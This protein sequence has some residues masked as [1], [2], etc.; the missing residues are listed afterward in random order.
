MPAWHP[1]G[2]TIDR[3][4]P[5]VFFTGILDSPS[6]GDSV[7]YAVVLVALCGLTLASAGEPE[8]VQVEILSGPGGGFGNLYL[9]GQQAVQRDLQLSPDQLAQVRT[10]VRDLVDRQKAFAQEKDQ[11]KRKALAEEAVR[12]RLRVD[13]EIL[14]LLK[15]GQAERL[16]QISLQTRSTASFFD[17]EVQAA[18]KLTDEQIA[19][20]RAIGMNDY[21]AWNRAAAAEF[22]KTRD[23]KVYQNRQAEIRKRRDQAQTQVLTAEQ[24]ARWRKMIGEPFHGPT[25]SP[26]FIAAA[27]KDGDKEAERVTRLARTAAA[28]ATELAKVNEELRALRS[29][30]ERL[31][32]QI[33]AAPGGRPR[34]VDRGEYVEDVRTGLWWQKDGAASGKLNYYDAIQY[35]TGLKLGGQAG[36]RVPTKEELGAI[37]PALEPPFTNTRY[38]KDPVGKGTGEYPSYWTATL[39]TRLPDYA[40]VYQWYADGG[41]NNCYAS[42]NLAYVRCVR[43]P[44]R[45]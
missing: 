16:R 21:S 7:R 4:T 15:P 29:E 28:L 26:I 45:K 32:R 24:Q 27:D 14:K 25:P 5:F 35:A 8:L 3:A 31:R 37:F 6:E 2:T 43:D 12:V 1:A 10:A 19:K 20:I 18:L 38:N 36:W 40:Y 42:R 34:F 17:P 11:A 33:G 41:A 23:M 22:R 9:L 13:R 44:T 39:D 30:N